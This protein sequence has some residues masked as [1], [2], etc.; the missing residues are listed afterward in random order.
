MVYAKGLFSRGLKI[1]VQWARNNLSIKPTKRLAFQLR[2]K[3]G[4]PDFILKVLIIELE[5]HVWEKNAIGHV[6]RL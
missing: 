3:L 5:V 6:G 1:I 2:K 4:A